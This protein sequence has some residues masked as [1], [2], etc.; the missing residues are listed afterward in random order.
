[1]PTISEKR[2]DPSASTTTT[3]RIGHLGCDELSCAA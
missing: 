3:Q 2:I 1:L